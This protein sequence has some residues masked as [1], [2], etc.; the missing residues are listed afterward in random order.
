M[1]LKYAKAR[2][3]IV[4]GDS[5]INVGAIAASVLIDYNLPAPEEAAHQR[6]RAVNTMIQRIFSGEPQVKLLVA[7]ISPIMDL[8]GNSKYQFKLHKEEYLITIQWKCIAFSVII[9][10]RGQ[11]RTLKR[12]SI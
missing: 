8:A 10:A 11:V 1:L 9:S 2:R 7:G 12:K 3:A 6:R 5:E 4:T